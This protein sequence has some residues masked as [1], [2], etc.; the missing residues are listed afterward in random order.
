ML[1]LVLAAFCLSSCLSSH[2]SN[3][4]SE[5]NS[6]AVTS[7]TNS[8]PRISGYPGSA[9][10][11]GDAYSFTPEASDADGDQLS[12]AI[13]N[14]PRWASFNPQSGRLSGQVHLGDEG[15]YTG[16]R[17]SVSDGQV[18][19]QLPVFSVTVTSS[20]LGSLTMR[21]TLPT[22]NDDGSPI[23]NLAGYYIYYGTSWGA[24][25]NRIQIDNPSVSTYVVENLLPGTYYLAATSF[26]SDG[27]ESTYSNVAISTVH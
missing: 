20:G 21:W 12:F 10:R 26:T 9:V 24:Y 18:T 15:E 19:T 7:S 27:V 22:E 3:A 6:D 16:I 4:I 23:T 2:N 1:L 25:T 17:I 11:V 5:S 13:D 14:K 8:P